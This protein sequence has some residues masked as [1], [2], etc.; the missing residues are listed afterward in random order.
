MTHL[1]VDGDEVLKVDPR[2]HLDPETHFI[3][4]IFL[5]TSNLQDKKGVDFFESLAVLDHSLK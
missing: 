1:V 3:Q 5:L 4:L 2:A